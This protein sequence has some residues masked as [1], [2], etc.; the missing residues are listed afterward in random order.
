MIENKSYK[1]LL[2][3]EDRTDDVLSYNR[4]DRKVEVIFNDG[5]K[6]SYNI[7]NVEIVESILKE[8]NTNNVLTYLKEVANTVGLQVKINNKELNILSNHFSKIDFIPTNSILGSYLNGQL[9]KLQKSKKIDDPD[10][11]FPFGFNLSQK[12]AVERALNNKLSIIEGPPGTGKTQTIL[13]LVANIVM[14]GQS[15]AVV[16]SNNS[17]TQNVFE[18]L[19]KYKVDF[20]VANLGNTANKNVFIE[21]QA[22]IPDI[23]NWMISAEE[24]MITL[25]ILNKISRDLELKLELKNKLSAIKQEFSSLEIEVQH[26]QKMMDLKNK[27]EINRKFKNSS[28]LLDLWLLAE[29]YEKPSFFR[30]AYNYLLSFFSKIASNKELIE[31]L[32]NKYSINDLI[33]EFQKKYYELK[34]QELINE[35]YNIEKELSLFKF[36]EK[37]NEYSRLSLKLFQ[38]NLQNKYKEGRSVGYKLSDL[39]FNA[40]DFLKDYPVVLS[41][42]YSL[43]TSLSRDMVYDYVIIDESSQVD[44]CTGALTL[45]CA[46]NLVVVGDLKQLPHV[47]DRN[48]SDATDLIFNNFKIHQAYRYKNHNIMSSLMELFPNIPVTLLKEHYRCHP[49]I[50]EFCNKKF[51]DGQLVIL[52]DQAMEQEPLVVYKTVEGKHA[53]N[54]SNQ[55]QVDIILTEII[56]KYDLNLNDGSVGI[57]SPY[58]NQTN[59][60]QKTFANTKVK[61]D[62]VDKFQGQENKVVILST[63]DNEITDFTD[64]A[65]RLN[66]AISRAINKLILIV[67]DDETLQ[68]RN[69]GDL[70]NYI[71]YNNLTVEHSQVSSVFDFLFKSYSDRR[72]EFLKNKKIISR[73]DS[74]NLMFNLIKNVF[75]ELNITS[76]DIVPHIPLKMIFKEPSLLNSEEFRFVVKTQSHVDFLIFDQLSKMPK[77]A[78]EVDGVSFHKAGERQSER[79]HMKDEIFKKYNIP[80]LRFRTD[81][82]NEKEKLTLFLESFNY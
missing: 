78:I 22:E 75:S 13:N 29:E 3:G 8:E 68:D 26:F 82:S 31:R 70:I 16:S 34:R 69:I 61:A 51:Y 10:I 47:V 35:I 52:T 79:D 9:I 42:T 2:K 74:E 60:L 55:R 73:F 38:S 63:V 50:I 30:K 15:V 65:Q 1:I 39:K 41:T 49:K 77:Y 14:N 76:L 64:N 25:R 81:G 62:T 7:E 24:R 59:L 71:E 33:T 58:R 46:K 72:K 32:A 67:N 20:I 17:A 48:M 6:F 21:N 44:V 66:V 36:E 54:R 53:R 57:I 40:E 45:S 12:I 5:K 28:D 80:L 37:M 4:G 11:V 18:K 19:L 27:V 56:P 43:L 23:K